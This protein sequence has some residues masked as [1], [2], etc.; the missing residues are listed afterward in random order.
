MTFKEYVNAASIS[1]PGAKKRVERYNFD[2]GTEYVVSM[3]SEVPADFLTAYPVNQTAK[4]KPQTKPKAVRVPSE[5]KPAIPEIE[6]AETKP[7]K[8]K[9]QTAKPNWFTVLASQ[10]A[11][12]G[13]LL[14]LINWLETSLSFRGGWV[15]YGWMGLVVVAAA[16]AFYWFVILE[17]KAGAEGMRRDLS[18]F[19]CAVL[20]MLFAYLHGQAFYD[21]SPATST[22]NCA[23]AII[24]SGLGWLSIYFTIPKQTV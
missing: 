8:P 1:V 14:L 7:A 2:N 10:F 6:T 3:R 13:V 21:Y 9:Q 24:V 17:A 15:K 20:S 23:F 19:I 5:T 22:E 12:R 16:I 18:L 4:P 11:N